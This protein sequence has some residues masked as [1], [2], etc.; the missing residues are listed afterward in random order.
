M[1][2][3]QDSQDKAIAESKDIHWLLWLFMNHEKKLK[4]SE[5]HEERQK[6]KQKQKQK[7]NRNRGFE[8][9]KEANAKANPP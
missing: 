3:S 2:D 1:Q 6:Q 8:P 7:Q 5:K 4:N 9:R